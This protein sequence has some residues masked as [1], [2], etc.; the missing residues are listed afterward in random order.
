MP[1]LAKFLEM[2]IKLAKFVKIPNSD[3]KGSE[4]LI[5]HTQHFS[6]APFFILI[7]LVPIQKRGCYIVKDYKEVFRIKILFKR[8]S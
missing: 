3:F 5:V 8:S 2:K 1:K 6:I 4:S 7:F